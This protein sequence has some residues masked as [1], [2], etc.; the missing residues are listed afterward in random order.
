MDDTLQ[1]TVSPDFPPDRLSGWF[2]FNTWLQ[3]QLGCSVHLEMYDGFSA[4][5]A[6]VADGR[7]DL[8]YANPF[9]ATELVRHRGFV[10]VARPQGKS[11]EVIIISRAGSAQDAI[12]ALQPGVRVACTTDPDVRQIGL[13]LLEPANLTPADLT[14]IDTDKH[15]LSA[16]QLLKSEADIAFLLADA[17]DGFSKLLREQTQVLVRSAIRD[18]HHALLAGPRLAARATE[19]QQKLVAMGDSA[20]DRQLLGE[21]DFPAWEAL[22]TE[23]VEFMID[24]IDT[25]RAG[26]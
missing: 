22:E 19:L 14:L 4:Q 5:R 6:A 15:L 9:D 2:V 26:A 18:I 12:E 8:I 16:K 25:L 7:V 24:V 20:T 13:I 3:R 1:F 10:P 23:D 21:L 17:Y 11:D